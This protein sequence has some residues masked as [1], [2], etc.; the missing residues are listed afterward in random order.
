M[1]E[2]IKTKQVTAVVKSVPKKKDWPGIEA[3][4]KTAGNLGKNQGLF[5]KIADLMANVLSEAYNV[6]PNDPKMM[7]E[8]NTIVKAVS[9]AVVSNLNDKLS[10]SLTE[11]QVKEIVSEIVSNSVKE[12]NLSKEQYQKLVDD[13]TSEVQSYASE[14]NKH[15]ALLEDIKSQLNAASESLSKIVDNKTATEQKSSKQDNADKSKTDF[16]QQFASFAKMLQKITSICQSVTSKQKDLSKSLNKSVKML[17]AAQTTSNKIKDQV[18]QSAK[19]QTDVKNITT[20]GFNQTEKQI[21]DVNNAVEEV[22]E[23][24]KSISSGMLFSSILSGIPFIGGFLSMTASLTTGLFKTFILAPVKFIFKWI[25]GPIFKFTV[26][27]VGAAIKGLATIIMAPI[28]LIAKGVGKVLDG[29]M[30]IAAKSFGTFIM[31]PAGMYTIGYIAGFVWTMWLKDIWNTISGI[32][33]RVGKFF[34]DVNS[35][36]GLNAAFKKLFFGKDAEQKTW[37][38]LLKTLIFGDDAAEKSW[39]ELLINKIKEFQSSGALKEW[40][41][42]FKNLI[43]GEGSSDKKWSDLFKCMFFGEGADGKTWFQ[44]FLEK[45]KEIYKTSP[46]FAEFTNKLI[47]KVAQDLIQGTVK[48][49]QAAGKVIKAV[50]P[51]VP[52]TDASAKVIAKE[53][54]KIIAEKTATGV[55]KAVGKNA[56]K[57]GAETAGKRLAIRTGAKAAGKT[58]AK[59]IWGIG[60]VVGLGYA[61]KRAIEGDW[62][63]AGL[64][65][66]SGLVSLVPG[67]GTA[68]SVAMDI[69]IS[70]RDVMKDTSDEIKSVTD[71]QKQLLDSANETAEVVDSAISKLDESK[72][73]I[74]DWQKP[75][76][77]PGLVLKDGK[78]IYVD[79]GENNSEYARAVKTGTPIVQ[80]NTTLSKDQLQQLFTRQQGIKVEDV[81]FNDLQSALAESGLSIGGAADVGSSNQLAKNIATYLTDTQKQID[82]MPAE[83]QRAWQ[84]KLNETIHRLIEAIDKRQPQQNLMYLQV[85]QPSLNPAYYDK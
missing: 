57:E 75:G 60:A 39:S 56:V 18:K 16:N 38:E 54:E 7:S 35:G 64:E 8:I 26:G 51:K 73:D 20:T 27:F 13:I 49:A 50:K 71:A 81:A 69:G 17:D 23:N 59:A 5:D 78:W 33:D 41:D 65:A 12:S 62:T 31:S 68:A 29:I 46:E 37:T 32:I 70:V 25:L 52:K 14:V 82:A 11:N 21:K 55:G 80:A 67:F 83:E 19:I 48:T 72:E 30:N 6:K 79:D 44:L 63:G 15:K 22:N 76:W 74:P 77:E 34:D 40:S 1:A 2:Q 10:D 84:T 43:F 9:Q 42:L 3:A 61:V 58:V 28:K 24:V 36:N 66:A 53:G 45:F 4:K 47:A 85:G